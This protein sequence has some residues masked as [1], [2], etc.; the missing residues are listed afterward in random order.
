MVVVGWGFRVEGGGGLGWWG[1]GFWGVI[2]GRFQ[3]PEFLG[4][5]VFFWEE[6][7]HVECGVWGADSIQSKLKV[8]S[9]STG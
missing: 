7:G 9:R 3:E 5:T 2:G 8:R 4:F 6:A 1:W